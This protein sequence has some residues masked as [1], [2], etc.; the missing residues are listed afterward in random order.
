MKKF[1]F[2]KWD[3]LP[4]IDLYMDQVITYLN[5]QLSCI[6]FHDEKFITNSMINNYVKTGI[7]KPPVKKHYTKQHIAYFIV[8]TILKK[9]YSMSEISQLIQIQ[10]N[11]ENST[12][13]QAYDLF[14]SCFE[15]SLNDVFNIEKQS[16]FQSKNEQQELM[17]HV[18][19]CIINKIYSEYS[20]K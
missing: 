5:D 9:C 17:H 19:Q 6:F 4:P 7:V 3:G 16:T 15:D 10:T 11:M 20:L 18:V 14:I 1:E 8:V 2:T 12:I 13:E